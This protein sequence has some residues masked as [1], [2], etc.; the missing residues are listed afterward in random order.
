MSTG[1][2]SSGVIN[3]QK[4]R[5]RLTIVSD[6]QLVEGWGALGGDAR[7]PLF[8]GGSAGGV[9]LSFV[10]VTKKGYMPAHPRKRNQD[11]MFLEEHKPTGSLLVGV[12]DGHGEAGDLVSGFFTERLPRALP[13]NPRF[14]ADPC[15]AMVEELARVEALLLEGVFERALPIPCRPRARSLILKR[16]RPFP[17][18][19]RDRL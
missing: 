8:C 16:A 9:I 17:R 1:K 19:T 14:S 15:A 10:G 3:V 13:A 2:A 4:A 7:A 6:S 12:F 11:A 5:R 18:R